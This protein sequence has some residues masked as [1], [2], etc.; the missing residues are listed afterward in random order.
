MSNRRQAITWANAGPFHLHKHAALEGDGLNWY[1]QDTEFDFLTRHVPN[2]CDLF[3]K[4]RLTL[5]PAWINNH[6]NYKV[7]DKIT[8][9]FPNFKGAAVD[10]C[11]V[12]LHKSKAT[13]KWP[14]S[15]NEAGWGSEFVPLKKREVG[16]FILLLKLSRTARCFGIRTFLKQY[17][18]YE[19]ATIWYTDHQY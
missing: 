4:H 15:Q 16:S 5:I 2:W 13:V 17:N 18:C 7:W 10:V 1:W 6:I 8:Y 11:Q 3:Y 14:V 12:S 9:P 19:S